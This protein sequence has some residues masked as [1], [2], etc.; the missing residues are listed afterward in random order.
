MF[1]FKP[2]FLGQRLYRSFSCSYSY[3]K[4]FVS[5][6]MSSLLWGSLCTLLIFSR[7]DSND[8]QLMTKMYEME[9]DIKNIKDEVKELKNKK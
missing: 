8:S 9:K 1:K 5:P 6:F 3:D 4:P 7:I 2:N